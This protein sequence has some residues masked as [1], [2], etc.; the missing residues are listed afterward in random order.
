MVQV[1]CTVYRIVLDRCRL[2]A[3]AHAQHVVRASSTA[4]Y[5]WLGAPDSSDK[6]AV[7]S[8][9]PVAPRISLP[10]AEKTSIP[11]DNAMLWR[12]ALSVAS[13]AALTAAA[14]AA[15]LSAPAVSY[16][17]YAPVPLWSGLYVGV[18]AGGA[19]ANMST[20]DL[21]SYWNNAR[22]RSEPAI[23]RQIRGGAFGGTQAGYNMQRGNFIYGVEADFGEMAISG[24]KQLANDRSA[25][26]VAR[27]NTGFY[28]DL[29]GRFGF[30][31]GTL[32]LYSKA[33]LAV[34]S[35][36]L[37]AEEPGVADEPSF[38][39]S[40]VGW[41]AGGGAEYLLSPSWS[42][43]AEYQHFD[44]G[45]SSSNLVGANGANFNFNHNLTIDTVKAGLNYHLGC[46][47]ASLK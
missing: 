29:T 35:A 17:D 44:F 46:C 37:R 32:M 31:F 47:E 5:G 20:R 26:A 9:L 16:K 41:T 12:I 30:S 15:D 40:Q 45:T 33:G 36:K 4:T 19:W 2:T 42:I 39:D 8:E 10:N 43:K 25:E 18:H 23:T 34:I 13:V 1:I 3:V 22:L 27:I 11:K 14:S 28:G 21:D 38:H 24:S 6:P 7:A